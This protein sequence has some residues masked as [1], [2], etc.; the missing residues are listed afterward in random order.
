MITTLIKSMDHIDDV[1]MEAYEQS[2]RGFCINKES[3]SIQFY[4]KDLEVLLIAYA[5]D[6]DLFQVK[7]AVFNRL[8]WLNEIHREEG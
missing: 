6:L 1:V 3:K 5:I 8:K 2:A 4:N 7:T